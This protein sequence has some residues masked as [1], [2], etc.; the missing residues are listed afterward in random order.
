MKAYSIIALLLMATTILAHQRHLQDDESMISDEIF[1]DTNDE[2]VE[3]PNPDPTQEDTETPPEN[4]QFTEGDDRPY[5]QEFKRIAKEISVYE[6]EYKECLDQIKM[7]NYNQEK[8]NECV[9]ENFIK[10]ALDVKYVTMKMMSRNE[11]DLRLF[12]VTGCYAKA[13]NNE[14]FSMACDY[15]ERDVLDLM[16]NGLDITGILKLNKTK[17][18]SE[19]A[20]MPKKAFK[21]I[22]EYLEP[23]EKEFF[24]LLDEIDGVKEKML[25]N[26]KLYIDEKTNEIVETEPEVTE[27]DGTRV[28]THTIHIQDEIRQPDPV[29][30][31]DV[32]DVDGEEDNNDG[33]DSANKEVVV[34]AEA[35][36]NG[37]RRLKRI[38]ALPVKQ[39][40]YIPIAYSNLH[41]KDMNQKSARRLRKLNKV[42]QAIKKLGHG[43][44]RFTSPGNL[45]T[46]NVHTNYLRNNK[47][48]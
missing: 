15:L 9:G 35:E 25:I 46:K 24:A 38:L 22:I 47:S 16:W 28:I 30:A 26:I 13:A 42:K 18:L 19:Y 44:S 11:Q 3:M 6:K 29:D 4:L 1:A 31:I 43:L 45:K 33:E 14:N 10:M 2:N 17:Y 36:N 32:S 8:I 20:V 23:F 41:G 5:T 40:G 27:D 48:L 12:F 21:D 34:E 7:E 39:H 37:I